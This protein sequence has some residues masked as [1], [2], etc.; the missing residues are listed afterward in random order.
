MKLHLKKDGKVNE[1][2]RRKKKGLENSCEQKFC[3]KWKE[4]DEF[5]LDFP[6]VI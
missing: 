4:V 1:K 6:D 5:E 2:V 3:E